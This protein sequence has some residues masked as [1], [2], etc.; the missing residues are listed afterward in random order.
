M[1]SVVTTQVAYEYGKE[2]LELLK[3]AGATVTFNTYHSL[4]HSLHPQELEDIVNFLKER[5][6]AL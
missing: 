5:L 3:K 4:G 1:T 6:P 2:S